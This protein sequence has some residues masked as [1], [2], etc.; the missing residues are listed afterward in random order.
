MAART[1]L[2]NEELSELVWIDITLNGENS[3]FLV[4]AS[5]SKKKGGPHPFDSGMGG[6]TR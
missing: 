1:E 6:I 2:R 4:R 3:H 5:I